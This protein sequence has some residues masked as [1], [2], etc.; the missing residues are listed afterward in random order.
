M[1]LYDHD[2]DAGTSQIVNPS[3]AQILRET[4]ALG[5]SVEVTDGQ[6]HL[7]CL[8]ETKHPALVANIKAAK[9]QL[10]AHLT[11]SARRPLTPLQSAYLLGRSNTVELGG[12]SHTY[13]EIEGHW[14][15]TR[16]E[17]ALRIVVSRHPALRTAFTSDG[18]QM[19]HADVPVH[20]RVRDLRALPIRAREQARAAHRERASHWVAPLDQPPLVHAEVSVLTDDQMVL[21]V[22]HDG[23][24]MDASSMFLF[25]RTWWQ[26]YQGETPVE[27]EFS[28]A[29]YFGEL[30][31]ARDDAAV[32]RSRDYWRERLDDLAPIP[33][34]PLA[35]NPAA[36]TRPRLTR[37]QVR[38]TVDRWA[39]FKAH[40]HRN[41]ITPDAALLTAYGQVL[42]YWGGG[43]RFTIAVTVPHSPSVRQ[44]TYN[45]IGNFSDTLP[46]EIVVGPTATFVQRCVA[47]QQQLREAAEHQHVSG[48]EL[49]QEAGHTGAH[50]RTPY[51]FNC[52]IGHEQHGIDGSALELFG[53]QV[54]SASQTPQTYLNVFVMEQT[55]GLLTHID[56]VD[57]LY[58]DGLP[59]A[60]AAGY[61][62]LLDVLCDAAAWTATKHDLLPDEQ[63]RRR[64]ETN[65]TAATQ[66]ERMLWE[67]VVAQATA[68]PSAPAV[69]TTSGVVSYG[70]LLR[71]AQGVSAWL[72]ERG[73]SHGDLV[74]LV[75][76][77]GPE[78][79]IG[80]LASL[81]AGAA[82]LPIDAGLPDERRAYMLRD[83]GVQC[84]LTNVPSEEPNTLLLDETQPLMPVAPWE[85][86]ADAHVDDLAY[87]LYTSGT[88]GHPKG[89]MVS[90]R[91]VANVI[92]DCTARFGVDSTDRLFG[93][94]A[95]NFDLSVYDI[96]GALSVGA[97]IVLPDADQA[98]DPAH[99]L[100][101]CAEYGVTVW[102]SVPAIVAMLG[103]QA[104]TAPNRLGALRLVMMSG[105][106]IPPEL[107]AALLR[108]K[109][110][111]EVVSLG[112]PTETTIW[113]MI[114]PVNAADDGSR[115]IPYGRP[116]R[117]NTAFVRSPEGWDRPDWVTGEIW[118]GGIG[119]AR[120]Y[121]RD[122]AHT[123]ERFTDGL[124]R[125][126]DFGRFLPDGSIEILGRS[127]FQIK[128][129]GYRIEAG[130]VET[131][132]LA[133]PEIKQAAVVRQAGTR[134]D[135][136]VAHLV[137][138][139]LDC[140]DLENLRERLTVDLPTYMVPS[141]IVWH[142]A[143]PLTRNGK[144]DRGWLTTVQPALAPARP[145][146]AESSVASGPIPDGSMK[147]ELGQLWS[148]MLGV[149]LVTPDAN[150]YDLGAD[151]LTVIR[152]LSEVRRR[153]G[154]T[155]PL[156][157]IHEV[158][159]VHAMAARL[160]AAG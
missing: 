98:A 28:F 9:S 107:P 88:T 62:H 73:V 22:N 47:V 7:H 100:D 160:Q 114:H 38:L 125:T 3:V 15:V 119:L 149:P 66:P 46:V 137:S 68:R 52:A 18:R 150:L 84:V 127:D 60:L 16:L 24:I 31:D 144:V 143:L 50:S 49:L 155:I 135:R 4:E 142:E 12:A 78:Q 156:A 140:P 116:N 20:I 37:R 102:N 129:N 145:V 70:E 56:A 45:T 153:F 65:E 109:P 133:A 94:S 34:L 76:R 39:A 96:F 40:A 1:N 121:H 118:A 6:L 21:H 99:W 63:R 157:E 123:A 105:D 89:V 83:G 148:S 111:L 27:A 42:A 8:N 130:E 23:L 69:I 106:R 115:P 139:G 71:R 11:A 103:E 77:R 32:Q 87:V 13:H 75:M 120:G 147:T 33:D 126:G 101:L 55:C 14:D 110:S 72:S 93:I 95:F 97:A 154:V 54:F 35:A 132:L 128:V 17:E 122:P 53:P 138:A 134:G 64:A 43:E 44:R 51:T 117:N 82:Y 86:P 108:L 29:D 74:G 85:P 159:T 136:L 61:Q 151:S 104:V 90:H 152:I 141:V 81:L 10:V 131:R 58:P 158:C 113:N 57:Q 59:S 41:G 146:A 30:E 48:V 124:Y 91:N 67:D 2:S 80:I 112:G 79:I 19:V 5:L 92:T 25:F 26:A 36:V